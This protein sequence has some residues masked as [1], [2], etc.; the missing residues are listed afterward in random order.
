MF[1]TEVHKI[2]SNRENLC[3]MFFL[4]KFT[5]FLLTR[6]GDKRKQTLHSKGYFF[7]SYLK[8]CKNMAA[9]NGNGSNGN[10]SHT[11]GSNGNGSSSGNGSHAYGSNGNGSSNGNGRTR[12]GT[13]TVK[14]GLAQMLKGGV[15]VSYLILFVRTYILCF[16][17]NL[18]L[19]VAMLRWTWCRWNRRGLPK[20][21]VLLPSWL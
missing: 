11:H 13:T 4:L 2:P 21:Q 18:P 8:N 12:V 1:A 6:Q 16:P 19:C 20:P 3:Q 10:G 14:Q 9:G 15:I 7:F 17:K 5:D